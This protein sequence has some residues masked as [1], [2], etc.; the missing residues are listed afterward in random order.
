[1]KKS[2]LLSEVKNS[3]LLAITVSVPPFE[4]GAVGSVV[5]GYVALDAATKPAPQDLEQGGLA[6]ARWTHQRQDLARVHTPSDALEDVLAAAALVCPRLGR[7]RHSR[8]CEGVLQGHLHPVLHVL[9][10]GFGVQQVIAHVS[11]KEKKQ[12]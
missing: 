11:L 4:A 2:S 10:L 5:V 7:K 6:A 8:R 9:K 3:C 12:E 1:V